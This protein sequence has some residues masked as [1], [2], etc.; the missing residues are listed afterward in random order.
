MDRFLIWLMLMPL[1]GAVML[2]S[3]AALHGGG[4]F[5]AVISVVFIAEWVA[6]LIMPFTL[7][8]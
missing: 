7:Q 4:I 5:W 8:K 2:S 1:T 3:E 6:V